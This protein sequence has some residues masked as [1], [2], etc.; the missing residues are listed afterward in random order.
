MI[1]DMLPCTEL[2]SLRRW[3]NLDSCPHVQHV[4]RNKHTAVLHDNKMI[5]FGGHDLK[6]NSFLGDLLV[7]DVAKSR[8]VPPSEYAEA[9]QHGNRPSCR[10]AHSAG[11]IGDKMIIF[12]GF[13]GDKCLNDIYSLDLNTYIWSKITPTGQSPCARGGH[14]SVVHNNSLLIFGGWDTSLKYHNDVWKLVCD[15]Q[16]SIF[17][18][19]QVTPT[20]STIPGGRVGHRSVLCNN[21]MI[22]FGGYGSDRYWND[23]YTF[24]LRTNSWAELDIPGKVKPRPRTYHSM[25]CIGDRCLVMGGCDA[26]GV[27]GDLWILNVADR[28]W[29]R[30]PF[31]GENRFA[32]TSV[33]TSS[34]VVY[35]FGGSSRRENELVELVVE[36]WAAPTSLQHFMRRY[37]VANKSLLSRVLKDRSFPGQVTLPMKSYM[38]QFDFNFIHDLDVLTD[39][40]ARKSARG[41]E[42]TPIGS[43]H[44]EATPSRSK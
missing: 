32:H 39:T 23:V 25:S 36:D 42:V 30:V 1:P 26:E 43:T 12:G 29:K 21:K 15:F 44:G 24:D 28:T 18:W 40:P 6:E 10:R 22:V 41:E 34:G 27:I 19:V 17:K 7:F 4:V 38:E 14:S 3:R 37:A 33:T 5:T 8:W 13:S 2:S 11:V 16:N 20:T 9:E 31:P 35:V